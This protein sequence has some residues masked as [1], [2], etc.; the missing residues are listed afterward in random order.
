MN[1]RER[2]LAALNH[3]EPDRI[4]IDLGGWVTTINGIAYG[5]LMKYWGL[6]LS[7]RIND[8]VCQTVEV[9]EVV[10]KKLDIDIRH[11]NLWAIAL[12]EL[13]VEEEEDGQSFVDAWGVKWRMPKR[14]GHY[15]DM[16]EHPLTSASLDD[17]DAYDWPATEI[18][19][20]SIPE[21]EAKV[22]DLASQDYAVMIDGGPGIFEYGQ[23][24]RGMDTFLMDLVINKDFAR[25][26]LEKVIE[27]RLKLIEE[28]LDRIGDKIDIFGAGDDLG[29]QQ[30]LMIE[31]EPLRK[32]G[33]KDKMLA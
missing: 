14:S 22:A 17:L 29:L 5:S 26:L 21:I 15:F 12:G 23:W 30:G 25:R 19:L 1:H 13:Q 10:L 20:E 18:P 8:P 7:P 4:P 27:I 11:V 3:E 32:R 28:L 6:N 9:D 2:V 33:P 16:V 31:A 24:L